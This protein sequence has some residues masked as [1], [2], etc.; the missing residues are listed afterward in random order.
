MF[1]KPENGWTDV[2]VFG[3]KLGCASNVWD[4]PIDTL[5][6]LTR[7]L[8]GEPLQ[9][10]FNAEGSWFGLVTICGR[11]Y[12]FWSDEGGDNARFEQLAANL[13]SSDIKRQLAQECIDDMSK[14]IVAWGCWLDDGDAVDAVDELEEQ[15]ET[16][17]KA[18]NP[19]KKK[20][21]FR[22]RPEITINLDE[23]E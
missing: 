23:T 11:L 7:W 1:T 20:N 12:A 17:T 9:L 6:A 21:T 8:Y 22:N 14:D 3:K 4:V 18:L 19:T 16:L 13:S 5:C 15:I 10:V 2:E